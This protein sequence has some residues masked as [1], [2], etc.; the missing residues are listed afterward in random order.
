MI[1]LSIIMPVFNGLGYTKNCLKKLYE[2]L[3][4]PQLNYHTDIILV[5]DCSTDGTKNW[6]NLNYPDTIILKGNGSLWWSGGINM[7]MNWALKELKADYILWWNNDIVPANDYFKVLESIF[8]SNGIET[9]IGSKIYCY[10]KDSIIWSMGGKFDPK[11]GKRYMEGFMQQDS[12]SF[13]TKTEADWLPGMGTIIPANVINKIGLLDETNFPQYHGD[14]DYTLRAKN[15]GIKIKVVPELKIWNHTGNSGE[16][17]NFEFK[18]LISSLTSIKS[19]YNIKK[20]LLFYKKY[21]SSYI[22]YLFLLKLYLNYIG[23][24]FKWKILSYIGIKRKH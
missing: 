19:I 20:D 3:G 17:H 4:N 9:I 12:D 6:V 21:S 15:Q 5:D 8:S 2:L 23:G 18:G 10:G 11:I 7:G 13:S 24:F 16:L 1:K 22:A 14:S